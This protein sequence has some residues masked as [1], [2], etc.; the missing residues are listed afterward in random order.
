MMKHQLQPDLYILTG[1]FRE[2]L[3]ETYEKPRKGVVV[4]D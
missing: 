3:T 4:D 2:H 1:Q